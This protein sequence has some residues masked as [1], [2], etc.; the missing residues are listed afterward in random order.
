[1][2]TS[3]DDYGPKRHETL[4]AGAADCSRADRADASAERDASAAI[5][6][7]TTVARTEK[8]TQRDEAA[9]RRDVSALARDHAGEASAR[10]AERK[11]ASLGNGHTPDPEVTALKESAA[12]LRATTASDRERAAGD[13]A[14][15][16]EDRAKAADDRRQSRVD[17]RAAHLDDLTGVY[18][19]GLGLLTLQHEIDRAHR[20]GEPFV[21]AFIDVDGL[22]QVND[23]QGHAAGDG[24]LQAVAAELRSKLRS[25][26]PIVRVGGDEFVCAFSNTGL[27]SAA[28]RIREIKAN[29]EKSQIDSSISVGFA[30]LCPGES[31]EDLTARGDAELYRFKP[32]S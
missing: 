24:L 22:K 3:V 11:E 6:A 19:R 12:T 13:R 2:T 1:M 23:Q 30:E 28:G 10:A 27:E 31:L 16:A 8:A 7:A 15:G 32:G 9:R 18:T 20:S 29:L 26:D 5:R 14:C 17:L 25:Y 21:L 4:D